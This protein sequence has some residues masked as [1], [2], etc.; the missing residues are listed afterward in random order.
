MGTSH[1]EML[2]EVRLNIACRLLVDS[3]KPLSEIAKFVGYSNPSSFSRTF[4]RLMKIK[5]IVYR[6][7]QLSDGQSQTSHRKRSHAAGQ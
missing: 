3:G 1:S 7:R 4:L 2:A 6:Q 5:P